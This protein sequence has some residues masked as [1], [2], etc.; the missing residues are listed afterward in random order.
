MSIN[1]L[2]NKIILHDAKIDVL[3]ED[4]DECVVSSLY[5]GYEFEK[6]IKD[7]KYNNEAYEI[8]EVQGLYKETNCPTQRNV[9][10]N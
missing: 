7:S 1:S 8:R 5:M 10:F 6:E 4:L 3:K 2:K 9:S